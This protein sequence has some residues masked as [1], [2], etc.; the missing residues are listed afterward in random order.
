MREKF[1]TRIVSQLL[2]YIL[3][4]ISTYV[5]LLILDVELLGIISFVTGLIGLGSLFADLGVSS[6]YF[7][8]NKEKNFNEIFSIYFLF[9]LFLIAANYIPFYIILFQIDSDIKSYLLLILT[10]TIV[11]QF[12]DIFL[13]HLQTKMKIYK[14]ELPMIFLSI[15]INI[16]KIIIVINGSTSP[17]HLIII[18]LGF[19]SL[20]FAISKFI[21]LLILSKGEYTFKKF[22]KELLKKYLRDLKPLIFG[23]ITNVICVNIGIVL[24]NISFGPEAL[25][26]FS[27]VNNY[28]IQSLLLISHSMNILYFSVYSALFFQN[29]VKQIEA[30]SNQIEKYASILFLSVVIL[31]FLNGKLFLNIFLPNYLPSLPYLMIMIFVPFFDGIKRP[32][33]GQLVPGKKQN[34]VALINSIKSPILIFIMILIIPINIFGLGIEGL[35]FLYTFTEIVDY[36]LYISLSRKIFSIKSNKKIYLHLI[37]ALITFIIAFIIKEF[38]LKIIMN[39]QVLLLIISSFIILTTFLFLLIIFKELQNKDFKFLWAL[40]NIKEHKDSFKN[41]LKK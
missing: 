33:S 30:I 10:S 5:M 18:L 2:I 38:L 40:L 8:Y 9:K 28:I 31:V 39:N 23:T 20:I 16:S 7:Q 34:I 3:N 35:A 27:L 19:N 37:L 32:Y 29:K 21:L 1:I 41:E 14:T 13:V 36:F 26:Y 24:I 15:G 6:I 17:G 22:K 12:A 25:G 11:S 4:M